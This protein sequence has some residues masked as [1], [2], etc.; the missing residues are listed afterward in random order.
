MLDRLCTRHRVKGHG[1][2]EGAKAARIILSPARGKIQGRGRSF[3]PRPGSRRNFLVMTPHPLCGE[4]PLTARSRPKE[5]PKY[6]EK[7]LPDNN[8]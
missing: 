7:S 3:E 1:D 2:D 8:S 4:R 6:P 5:R